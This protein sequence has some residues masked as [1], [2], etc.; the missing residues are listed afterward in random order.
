MFNIFLACFKIK[1]KQIN[2]IQ[3]VLLHV[4]RVINA[5]VANFNGIIKFNKMSAKIN[6]SHSM[7]HY[8]KLIWMT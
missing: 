6:I 1:N 7:D 3:I 5:Y 2:N 4:L 8:E